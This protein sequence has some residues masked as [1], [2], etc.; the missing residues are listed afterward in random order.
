MA[1]L[2]ICP[3]LLSKLTFYLFFVCSFNVILNYILNSSLS[4]KQTFSIFL[5][6]SL[7]LSAQRQ[8]KYVSQIIPSVCVSNSVKNFESKYLLLEN[9][10][11]NVAT[12]TFW[13]VQFQ[14]VALS[15]EDLTKGNRTV[16]IAFQL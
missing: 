14:D 12:I 8:I 16:T 9:S 3:H 10:G 15:T 1:P 13:P 2:L 4:Y 7:F 5:N 6:E 11:D